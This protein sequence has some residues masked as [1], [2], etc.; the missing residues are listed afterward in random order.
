MGRQSLKLRESS[1]P[2]AWKLGPSA[3]LL[4]TALAR[5]L[6][7]ERLGWGGFTVFCFVPKVEALGA[8]R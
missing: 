4:C 6:E 8:E 7:G 2:S 3:S 5:P 1:S